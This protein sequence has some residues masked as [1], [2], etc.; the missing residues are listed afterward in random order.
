MRRFK[1]KILSV[2]LLLLMLVSV[3]A[4]ENEDVSGRQN[5][6]NGELE[7]S[8]S[9]L[10]GNAFSRASTR[11]VNDGDPDNRITSLRVIAFKHA[12]G[13][14]A[15]NRQIDVA[16]TEADP[17]VRL[18]IRESIYDIVAICNE[19]AELKTLLENVTNRAGLNT[20]SLSADAFGAALAIPMVGETKKY[21]IDRDGHRLTI[22]VER[23]A[24]R[25]EIT[26][27]SKAGDNPDYEVGK[28][29]GLTLSG[30]PQQIPL[31]N[32]VAYT[33]AEP[34]K[35]IS[36]T[37]EQIEATFTETPPD[38]LPVPAGYTVATEQK[39]SRII[40]PSW[41]FNPETTLENAIQVEATFGEKYTKTGVLSYSVEGSTDKYY[42]MR[43]N[44]IYRLTIVGSANEGTFSTEM[45][46]WN[47]ESLNDMEVDAQ[48][49][50]FVSSELLTYYINGGPRTL[51]V[52]TSHPDGWTCE[53]PAETADW[54]TVTPLSGDVGVLTDMTLTATQLPMAQ[55]ER[56]G[57]FYIHAGNMKKRIRV[58][59]TNEEEVFIEISPATLTFTKTAPAEKSVQVT[60]TPAG[61]PIYF[62]R[63]DDLFSPQWE[64]GGVFPEDGTTKTK[65][66]FRPVPNTTGRELS[67]VITIYTKA[68]DGSMASRTLTIRQE[69]GD[70]LF[71]ASTR[72]LYPAVG[73]TESFTVS[74]QAPW[75]IA[76][77]T[78]ADVV[79][80]TDTEEHPEGDDMPYS[81]ELAPNPGWTQRSAKFKVTSSNPD[82][83]GAE[84]DI[85]QASAMPVLKD[86]NPAVV[87]LGSESV[88]QNATFTVNCG[89]T[90]TPDTWVTVNP[91]NGSW[92]NPTQMT[93][94][95]VT[96]TPVPFTGADGEPVPQ[97]PAA[98]S[99]RGTVR[100]KT[101]DHGALSV[102]QG[103]LS[104]TRTVPAFFT[105]VESSLPEGTL[106]SA[107]GTTLMVTVKTN[108]SWSLNSKY[109]EAS[110]AASVYGIR[111]LS[112]VIPENTAN[113]ERTI[114]VEVRNGNA[115][116][117]TLTFRQ[118]G[119]PYVVP[120]AIPVFASMGYSNFIG[121][122][123]RLWFSF[124][125]PPPANLSMPLTF[126]VEF[127]NKTIERFVV[128]GF[129]SLP[130]LHYEVSL[131][132]VSNLGLVD[133]FR[134]LGNSHAWCGVK[135]I[136]SDASGKSAE[137]RAEVQKSY[138][139]QLESV[140][141]VN[142]G[143]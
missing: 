88:P 95:A 4:C 32:N 41:V 65:F 1:D 89:W 96:L 109:G 66:M 123:R 21:L 16:D 122:A 22:P 72:P 108:N 142:R 70:L 46:P 69:A 82:F 126:R 134:T 62:S 107:D 48:F 81:F 103:L 86:F 105:F 106:I 84:V 101:Q 83:T 10:S 3:T 113:V 129:P 137:Y 44:T 77:V 24:A 18:N 39:A 50:L 56:S 59:Q 51:S 141:I 94:G 97:T 120:P 74:S 111:N 57:E 80:L 117:R 127:E 133:R 68:S 139:P 118:E 92:N 104:Y 30:F 34:G 75:Q 136:I 135:V 140:S 102:V 12:T 61:R 100:L 5:N 131:D 60:V 143:F 114:E 138:D 20:L 87:G 9:D 58:I 19:T 40:V 128:Y 33:R 85:I 8:V 73:G 121:T 13:E 130:V 110:A 124:A 11:A 119:K 37:R 71:Y 63:K 31:M 29:T 54:L 64:P 90:A 45:L 38:R 112:L 116:E 99:L 132:Y 6:N 15:D 93:T 125:S 42:T 35:T 52:E 27:H 53:L 14:V 25:L 98:G 23:I 115:V 79:T 2:S 17:V 28:L 67:S 78:P 43:R 91:D 36:F 55:V 49:K 47:S 26:A 76:S 7:I